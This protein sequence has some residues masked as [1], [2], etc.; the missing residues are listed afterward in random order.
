MTNADTFDKKGL[1]GIEKY[2][3]VAR[4]QVEQY[5]ELMA[6]LRQ[7]E[8]AAKGSDSFHAYKLRAEFWIDFGRFIHSPLLDNTGIAFA[9][10][11]RS[12]DAM[13]I[14][15]SFECN[16]TLYEILIIMADVNDEVH[17]LH[18]MIETLEYKADFTGERGYRICP[19][20]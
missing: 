16:R 8:T 15:W 13:E 20:L 17:D 9:N 6:R 19:F 14:V 4:Y 12:D 1:C 10:V 3:E 2:L 5:S 18:V 11:E 7:L